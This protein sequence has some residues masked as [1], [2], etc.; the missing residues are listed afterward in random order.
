MAGT[1][2]SIAYLEGRFETGDIPTQQDFYDLFASYTHYTNFNLEDLLTSDND[3][4]GIQIKNI[5]DP[6]APQDAVTLAYFEANLPTSAVWGNITG[7]FTDQTDAVTY[8][9]TASTTAENNAKAYA[10]GLVVGLWDDRGGFSAAGGAYPSSGGSGSAGA[11]LKGDIWTITTGG[12]LPTGQVVEIGDVIR[13]LINTPGNT[14]ANW[15]ITQNNLGYTAENS[16]NKSG[17]ISASATLYPNHNAVIAYAQPLDAELTAIAGLTSAADRLPYFT[18]SGTAALAVFTT[19]GRSLVDDANAAA[20]QATLGLV[21]GTN[22]QGYDAELTQIAGLAAPG[23]DRIL[24]WDHSATSYAYLSPNST[25]AI[26]TTSIGIPLAAYSTGAWTYTGLDNLD[27]SYV[28]TVSNTDGWVFRISNGCFIEINGSSF[29]IEVGS[30]VPD[31]SAIVVFLDNMSE[32]LTFQDQNGVGYLNFDTNREALQFRKKQIIN[33]GL[34]FEVILDE[35]ALVTP[36]TNSG[37][38]IIYSVAVPTNYTITLTLLIAEASTTASRKQTCDPASITVSNVA[39][40][41]T[42]KTLT[43]TAERI[44]AVTGGWN[45]YS[46]D[47]TKA[48][49]VRFQNEAVGLV[50]DCACQVMY[51]LRPIPV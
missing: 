32:A 7:T 18:G 46:N 34:G 5:A 47:T 51:V 16:A 38:H 10:D 20:A 28:W 1:P 33:Q 39:G 11:I 9:N 35:G 36:A 4:G 37:Q 27:S 48:V 30:T 13:A 12:T 3:G 25:L 15:A 49:D 21:I 8:I 50:Y 23:A 6:T 17:T 44:T 41:M 14:Q 40:T 31:G 19:Y 29:L 24:F 26:S 42:T 2:R 45:L 22:V 43:P